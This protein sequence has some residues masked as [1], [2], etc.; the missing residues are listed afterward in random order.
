MTDLGPFDQEEQKKYQKVVTRYE[1][2]QNRFKTLAENA[3]FNS[4]QYIRMGLGF[5]HFWLLIW[6]GDGGRGRG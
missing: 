2:L 6:V 4:D 3:V 1:K 5:A